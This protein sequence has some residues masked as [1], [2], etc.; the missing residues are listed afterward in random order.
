MCVSYMYV[1]YMSSAY[2]QFDWRQEEEGRSNTVAK[3]ECHTD[4]N[5]LPMLM[6]SWYL[7]GLM[8]SSIVRIT[9]SLNRDR[10]DWVVAICVMAVRFAIFLERELKSNQQEYVFFSSSIILSS[11]YSLDSAGMRIP[12]RSSLDHEKASAT[13]VSQGYL[14][15]PT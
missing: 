7:C 15:C 9:K 5:T 2:V 13:T 11:F 6:P 10:E 8:D 4:T 3:T 12:Q 14:A 1:S